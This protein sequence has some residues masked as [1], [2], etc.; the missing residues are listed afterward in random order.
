MSSV[1]QRQMSKLPQLWLNPDF[2]SI[3][4]A[5]ARSDISINN[6]KQ[7]EARLARFAPLLAAIFPELVESQGIIESELLA[8]PDVVGVENDDHRHGS[9][10]IK[11]DHALPVA[12][13][14][15]ARG[16][17][18][19][20]LEFAEGLASQHGL[21]ESDVGPL[22]L[23]SPAAQALF[24]QHDISVGSTGNL[25]LSI[26]IMAAALGFRATVH[27]SIDAKQWKKNRLRAQGVS[28]VEYS[29]D[30]AAAVNAGRVLASTNP[31]IY[32]VDDEKSLS[33][34][35]GYGVAALRLQTQLA[36]RN[37]LID[38]QHPLFVYLPCGVG[39]APA[40]VSFGLKKLFGD[41][42]HCFFIEPTT[43]ACFLAQMQNPDW[44]GITVYDV[45]LDNR[46]QADGLAV[47]G[48]SALAIREM[49][50]LLSG[51]VTT[52]DDTMF[53][54]LY[55]LHAQQNIK[56]EPSAAA[57][58]SGPRMLLT[59][60]AGQD[61]LNSHALQPYMH[62]ANHIV[63]TTGGLFIPDDEFEQFLDY[64]KNVIRTNGDMK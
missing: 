20:I 37:I 11:A 5:E 16:G 44:V 39:G 6:V 64:G 12:G 60:E 13:S 21:M 32:F 43:S 9:F 23:L 15:K 1:R 38:A 61:Y 31:N 49:R 59:T 46:T 7:A 17:I 22:A 53:A 41:D 45:G 3:N 56:V 2:A 14:I 51:I 10:W 63:W 26:G 29:S 24:N 47:P 25:G 18:H 4:T 57:A 55:W 48:A 35:L 28:V 52:T 19:E 54:D 50:A 42:V 36:A 58:V 30:Y 34:F 27:M 33:L 62:Q 40:G 8:L